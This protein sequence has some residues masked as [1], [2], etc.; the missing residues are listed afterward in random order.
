MLERAKVVET[1]GGG[2]IVTFGSKVTV[3]DEDDDDTEYTIV[4][5][6]EADAMQNRISNTSPM[7]KSLM[8]HNV[9]DSVDVQAPGGLIAFRDRLRLLTTDSYWKRYNGHTLTA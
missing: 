2:D 7:A 5:V 8:G 6:M 9:G 3:R 1:M 4:G